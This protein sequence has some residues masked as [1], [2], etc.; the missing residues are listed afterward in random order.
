MRASSL[1]A[2]DGL[3]NQEIAKTLGTSG[4]AVGKWR[5]RFVEKGIIG[6]NDDPRPGRRRLYG[7]EKIE[8]IVK[9]TIEEKPQDRTHWSTRSM[10]KAVGVGK[11]TVGKVWKAHRLKPHLEKH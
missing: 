7:P 2:V 4:N 10:A 5:R 8:E 6:L 11:T 3:K 9:K 1:L